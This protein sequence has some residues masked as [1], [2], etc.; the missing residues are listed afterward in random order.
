MINECKQNK[1]RPTV[2]KTFPVKIF[3]ILVFRVLRK[4]CYDGANF[5]TE[6]AKYERMPV[7]LKFNSAILAPLS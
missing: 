7:M 3:L 2:I 6:T 1:I 4:K 5:M